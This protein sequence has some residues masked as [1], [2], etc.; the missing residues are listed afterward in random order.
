MDMNFGEG[1][2]STHYTLVLHFVVYVCFPAH[3]RDRLQEAP[4]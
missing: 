3:L 1:N 4:G 2:C